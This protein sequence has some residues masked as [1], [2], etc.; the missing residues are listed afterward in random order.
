M[1]HTTYNM[2]HTTYNIQHTTYNIQQI[3]NVKFLKSTVR[4]FFFILK[5]FGFCNLL[6]EF[7]FV[8]TLARLIQ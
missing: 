5:L 4:M 3:L 1:Q 7:K 8:F 2:Q 6:Y